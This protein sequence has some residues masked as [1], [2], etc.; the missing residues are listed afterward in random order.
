[1]TDKIFNIIIRLM[2]QGGADAET[3]RGLVDIKNAMTAGIAVAGSI[4]AAYYA[5]DQVLKATVGELVT[6]ADSVRTIEQLTN[7]SAEASSRLVQITNF[8]K[9]SESDLE[10][11]SRKLATQGLSLTVETIARLSDEY[12]ALNTGAERQTFLTQ[13]MGRASAEWTNILSQG[14]QA[15]LDRNAAVS[16]GLIL[17]QATIDQAREYEIVQTDL[18][19]TTKALKYEIGGE[20]LPVLGVYEESLLAIIN[21]GDA[22]KHLFIGIALAIGGDATGALQEFD[23]MS[24]AWVADI[25]QLDQSMGIASASG[26]QAIIQTGIDAANAWLRANHAFEQTAD[27]TKYLK[28]MKGEYDHLVSTFGQMDDRTIAVGEAFGYLSDQELTSMTNLHNFDVAM[29]AWGDKPITKDIILALW[30]QVT[31]SKGE[32]QAG[33]NYGNIPGQGVPAAPSTGG[34]PYWIPDP[35]HPGHYKVNPNLAAGGSFSGWAMVGD[36]PGGGVTPY[37][38]WVYA[39]QGATVYNQSQM[40]GAAPMA[41][42]GS[43]PPMN[44]NDILQE[45]RSLQ[46]NLPRAIRDAVQQIITR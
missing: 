27:D 31:G 21:A 32:Q 17:T 37:T 10:V 3:V 25:K 9:I 34:V 33:V 1:M 23:L 38:E 6:Y 20:L 16:A 40:R 30:Y 41:G 4:T 5:V 2:K 42:G 46:R 22:Y 35:A 39:P 18:T 36:A 43:L 19:N 8:F 13:N 45:L 12:L 24:K 7:Q 15:I 44:N 28:D 29:Q 14:S 11:G 26:G